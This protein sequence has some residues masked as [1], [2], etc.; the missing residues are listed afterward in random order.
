MGILP[1]PSEPKLTANTY[2]KPLVEE[3]KLLWKWGERFSVSDSIFKKAIK[4]G[5]ICITCDIP[6]SRKIGGFMGHMANQGCSRCKRQF[7]QNGHLDFSGFDRDL[8]P[9]RTSDEHKKLARDTL[10]ETSPASMQAR[11]SQHGARYS[12]LHELEYFDCIRY[13]VVDPMHNL[14]LGTAKYMMKNVWLN[15][16]SPL[17][18]DEDFKKMQAAVDAM[19]TP[20]DI[21]RI[22]GK[23][24]SNFG[25]FTA[26][27]WQNWTVV[28]SMHALQDILPKKHLDCWRSFVKACK[29]LGKKVITVHD[30]Q[31]GDNHLINFLKT[32][33]E[34]YGSLK[35]T[36]NMHLHGHLKQYMLDYGP[37]HSFWCFSFERYNGVLGRYN[38]NNRSIEIQIQVSCSSKIKSA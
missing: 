3:L 1:G 11:C 25:G 24:S 27:Q 29:H 18:N 10:F 16:E 38:T 22:P 12:V 33:E 31:V 17:L 14:Y 35:V 6:A 19:V 23:I 13:F 36:P 28:Y 20:Q 8:W 30:I 9:P 2:L 5:L 26:D 32:F 21:G 34:L 15:E 7:S 4:V 37:F